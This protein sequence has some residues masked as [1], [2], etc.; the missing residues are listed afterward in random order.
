[1]SQKGKEDTYILGPSTW[2]SVCICV[3]FTKIVRF[4]NV[5]SCLNPDDIREDQNLSCFEENIKP[6][7]QV[8]A[9]GIAT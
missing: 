4:V 5:R 9:I 2:Q 3:V 8:M 6:S 7:I 1:M